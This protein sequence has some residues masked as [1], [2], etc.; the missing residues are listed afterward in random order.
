MAPLYFT[1]NT[2]EG[3]TGSITFGGQVFI[4]LPIVATGFEITSTTQAPPRPTMTVSNATRFVNPLLDLYDDLS[5]FKVTRIQTLAQYLDDGATPDSA[6]TFPIEVFYIEN[7]SRMDETEVQ[8]TLASPLDM[9]G[10]ML[11][12]RQ[13]IRDS[14]RGLPGFPGVGLSPLK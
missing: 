2:A 3:G 6:A 4:P 7:I 12:R 10:V 5:G 8:F 1:P 13:V 11:P 9:S 14:S